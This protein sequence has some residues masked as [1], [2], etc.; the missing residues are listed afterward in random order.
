MSLRSSEGVA[1]LN[2]VYVQ[3]VRPVEQAHQGEYVLVRPGGEMIFAASM[4]EL[5]EKTDQMDHW[6]NCIFKVG[7]ISAVNIL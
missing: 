2:R 6:D 3:H 5:F 7:D 1:R 4:P